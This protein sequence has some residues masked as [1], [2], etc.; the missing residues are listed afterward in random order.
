MTLSGHHFAR[1][2]RLVAWAMVTLLGTAS[3]LSIAFAQAPMPATPP[4]APPVTLA[5]APPGQGTIMRIVVQGTQRIEP[6]SVLSYMLLREGQAY[7]PAVADRSLKAL[8]DTGLFADVRMSWDG[9]TLTVNVV[10]N[11]ILN[12]VVYEGN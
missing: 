8:F 2:V 3:P 10:E 9:A 5:P 12:Q 6:D 4:V 7:D 11:P 1:G